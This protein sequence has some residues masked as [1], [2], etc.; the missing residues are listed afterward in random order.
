VTLA[1]FASRMAGESMIVP[2]RHVN[3][4]LE[5]TEDE[6]YELAST[7]KTVISTNKKM[8]GQQPYNMV[9]H[10]LKSEKDFHFHIE[11]YPRLAKLAGI[12]LGQDVFVN[13]I[14]PE[15]YAIRFRENFTQS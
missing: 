13:T 7:I 10:E 9:F 5:L 3:Y 15:D 1:P 6:R 4:I 12:E 8:F 11:I 2:R 14:V